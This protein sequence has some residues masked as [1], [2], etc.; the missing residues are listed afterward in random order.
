MLQNPYD[1]THFFETE[2][3]YEINGSFYVSDTYLVMRS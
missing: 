2:Y 1:I 3:T